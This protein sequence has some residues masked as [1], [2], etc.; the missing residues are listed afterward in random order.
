MSYKRTSS[1]RKPIHYSSEEED[2]D[3]TEK[4]RRHSSSPTGINHPTSLSGP[5]VGVQGQFNKE[6]V[7]ITIFC[8]TMYRNNVFGESERYP[9]A[10]VV[11]PT[12]INYHGKNKN[13]YE[14]RTPLSLMNEESKR[15]SPQHLSRYVL[16]IIFLK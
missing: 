13:L 9:F 3:I 2:K 15:K 16:Y 8:R 6:E 14:L 4:G 7:R 12:D 1:S 11:N 5:G 10:Q